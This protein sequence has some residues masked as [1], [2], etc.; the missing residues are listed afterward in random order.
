[1]SDWLDDDE[2][3]KDLRRTARAVGLTDLLVLALARTHDTETRD[4]LTRALRLLG[5]SPDART[6]K[7]GEP[8]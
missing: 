2:N 1:V 8:N 6:K 5:V 4:L 3:V 7:V